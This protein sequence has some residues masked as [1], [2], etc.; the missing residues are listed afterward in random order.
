[1]PKT[2]SADVQSRSAFNALRMP[3]RTTGKA[4]SHC[5]AVVMA[6]CHESALQLAV[7]TLN[8]T[9]G[10]SVVGSGSL[11]RTSK[12]LHEDEDLGNESVIVASDC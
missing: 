9:I 7:E 12:Q 6:M 10:G 1:M 5:A 11:A 2:N 4:V 8:H 3:S